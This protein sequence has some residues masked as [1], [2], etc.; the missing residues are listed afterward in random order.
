MRKRR[1][2][3][4]VSA[5][6]QTCNAMHALFADDKVWT[7]EYVSSGAKALEAVHAEEEELSLLL[8][9]IALADEDALAA[10]R[11]LQAPATVDCTPVVIML[12]CGERA[13]DTVPEDVFISEVLELPIEPGAAM[14]RIQ[15]LLDLHAYQM[16]DVSY[17]HMVS[18]DPLLGLPNG[19]A[20]PEAIDRAIRVNGE[21]R[22]L[23]L[24][25]NLDGMRAV[26]ERS[27]YHFGDLVLVD[28]AK[29]LVDSLPEDA[30]VGRPHGDT[31]CAYLP[32]R[33]DKGANIRLVE[34]LKARLK[35]FYPDA[36]GGPQQ[37]TACIGASAY[38][39]DGQTAWALFEAAEIANST[40]K[41][42]G[43]DAVLFYDPS[44]R[45]YSSD[46]QRLDI[47]ARPIIRQSVF[48]PV[49][50]A[51][52][53]SVLGYDY[54]PMYDQ[55]EPTLY[56]ETIERSNRIPDR[57]MIQHLRVNIRAFFSIMAELARSGEKQ[58]FVSFYSILHAE[59]AEMLP[60]MLQQALAEFQIHPGRICIHVSQE[61]VTKMSRGRLE[62]LAREIR[63]M[64]FCFGVHNVG[65]THLA[66]STFVE[67]QFD[68]IQ[69]STGFAGDLIK[70]LYPAAFVESVLR[71][72]VRLGVELCFP[73]KMR[74]A[75]IQTLLQQLGSRFGSYGEMLPDTA[76]LTRHM[77]ENGRCS[78]PLTP[79]NEPMAFRIS[80]DQY[81][82]IFN[83]SGIIMF[84]WRP[85]DGN[86]AFSESFYTTYG[87]YEEQS[88]LLV[89]LESILHPQDSDRLVD[90]MLQVKHGK[91]SADGI[92]RV[93]RDGQSSS[94]Y[95]WR[96]FFF[97]PLTQLDGVVTH[98]FCITIDIDREQRE[99]EDIRKQAEIDPLTGLYNRGATERYIRGFLDGPGQ[100]GY[101]A[102]MVVDMDDFKSLNDRLGHIAG[103]QALQ[104]LGNKMREMF[105]TADVVGRIGGDEFMVFLKNIQDED[106]IV[107]RATEICNIMSDADPEWKVSCSVGVARCPSDGI[108]FETLYAKADL[109]LYR[110]KAEG[111]SRLCLHA[112]DEEMSADA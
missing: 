58:P 80:S 53:Q 95:R 70:G 83:R 37:V 103:D 105:R 3:M 84:D 55:D 91:P 54:I 94:G 40:A 11:F 51:H 8:L 74:A 20:L 43:K 68:R 29:T 106:M 71:Y 15:V 112:G 82:E 57:S 98:V 75:S 109:A 52:D 102:L 46:F 81:N 90:L 24:N 30:V 47:E 64:G 2:I 108:T 78:K 17:Q 92:F 60:Q 10:V 63:A 104:Y 111:K 85:H 14:R 48:V 31:F 66:T 110:A 25:V 77:H 12:P 33:P 50:D 100:S 67:Q 72:Y 36:P 13:A 79:L 27:G 73:V 4:V 96:R 86:I 22:G 107:R 9:D 32:D 28:T 26:N 34:E 49:L 65:M 59:Q 6:E 16:R 44:M 97:S 62:S 18:R 19:K 7:C 101:H 88:D 42:L 38:P 21:L 39:D 93:K 5:S 56:M 45:R 69:F 87:Y 35:R 76:S 23:L 99:M 61:M 89:R 41:R 1:K